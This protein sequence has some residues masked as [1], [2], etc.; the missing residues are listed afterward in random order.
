L[1]YHAFLKDHAGARDM[2]AFFH[3]P[4]RWPAFVLALLGLACESADVKQCLKEYEQAQAIVNKVDAGA[5]DSV[6]GSLRSVEGALA[7]CR[8]AERHREVAELVNAK[9]QLEAQLAAL[10]KKA[11][12]RKKRKAKPEELAE[13]AKKG[14]PNCPKGQAY[15]HKDLDKEV[16]C[17]GPQL[18]EMSWAQAK[19]Y[20]SGRNYS[21]Q[22]GEA[23]PTLRAEYGGERF[24]FE[25]AAPNDTRPPKCLTL[26]P[27]PGVPWDEATARAT[28][29]APDKL[30]RDRPI[31]T[32]RGELGLRVQ[33]EPNKLILR[34][35]DCSG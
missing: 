8:K 17:T 4:R 19:A 30:E 18:A 16:K 33:D 7:I 9:N 13:L 12:R 3:H 31:K 26:Y 15:R 1:K 24:V 6:Q 21:I 23:P 2:Q 11:A 5:S 20:F 34:I 25:Y 29:A 22:T 10:E 27:A 35:G 28:G 32:E 14:D